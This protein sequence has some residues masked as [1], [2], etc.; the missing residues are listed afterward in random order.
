M[1]KM[2][3]TRPWL[4]ESWALHAAC[5]VKTSETMRL[6]IVKSGSCVFMGAS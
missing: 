1:V 2:S 6:A 3:A 4:E 5:R